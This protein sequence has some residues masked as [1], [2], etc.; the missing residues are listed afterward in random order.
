ML[1]DLAGQLAFEEWREAVMAVG[2]RLDPDGAEPGAR[3]RSHLSVSPTQHVASVHGE[4]VGADAVVAVHSLNAVADELFRG[5]TAERDR[6]GEVRIPPRSE[7]LAE[8]FVELCRRG[9][10][11]DPEAS[12]RPRTEASL[13][14][15]A[16]G[17]LDDPGTPVQAAWCGSPVVTTPDGLRVPT[18]DAAMLVCSAVMGVVAMSGAGEPLTGAR[19]QYRPSR[20]QRRDLELRDGGCTFPGCG[21]PA[22]WTDAHHVTPWPSGPTALGNF[23][24]GCRRHHRY[25]HREGWSVELVEEG[26]TRWTSPAGVAR[27]GQRHRRIRA[28]P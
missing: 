18:S 3:E 16:D 1:C 24:L 23:A 19:P 4:F 9:Q 15:H 7:L 27:W 20:R 2:R 25:V 28:G 26:W 17:C 14:V 22:P 12:A 21:V 11:V 13:V 6:F 8:A 10:G 5:Y